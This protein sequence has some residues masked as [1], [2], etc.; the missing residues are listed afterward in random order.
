MLL[1]LAVEN[2]LESACET[3]LP[4]ALISFEDSLNVLRTGVVD[5]T[6]LGVDP[7]SPSCEVARLQ[8][9]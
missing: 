1:V 8:V 3:S 7:A 4:A 5:A 9:L 2:A 6:G